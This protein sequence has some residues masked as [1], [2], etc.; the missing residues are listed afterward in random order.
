MHSK[1]IT[2]FI[3]AYAF[4]LQFWFTFSRNRVIDHW[5]TSDHHPRGSP[6]QSKREFGVDIADCGAILFGLPRSHISLEMK[7]QK[8]TV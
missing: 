4:R 8:V 6:S 7:L 3:D 1:P 5:I 2:Q